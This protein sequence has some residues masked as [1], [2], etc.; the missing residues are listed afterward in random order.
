MLLVHDRFGCHF[1]VLEIDCVGAEEEHHGDDEQ[2]LGN[3]RHVEGEVRLRLTLRT[4]IHADSRHV[5]SGMENDREDEGSTHS[6]ESQVL[7][8]DG[9]LGVGMILDVAD[10]EAHDERVNHGEDEQHYS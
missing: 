1:R 3:T 9:G 7:Q 5:A 6:I 8:H 4:L 10:K 2:P